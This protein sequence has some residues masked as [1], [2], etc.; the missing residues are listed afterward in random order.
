MNF[1]NHILC[2]QLA[3]LIEIT[4]PEAE[5]WIPHGSHTI[6]WRNTCTWVNSGRNE[7]ASKENT[8]WILCIL[9]VDFQ[10]TGYDILH[11]IIIGLGKRFTDLSMWNIVYSCIIKLQYLI[12][13]SPFNI[14]H[15]S[16]CIYNYSCPTLY[17]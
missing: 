2:K 5:F 17:I 14:F 15:M 1:Q 3:A 13:C 6:Q 9:F 10:W 16:N 7:E 4:G 8:K 11:C 12:Y